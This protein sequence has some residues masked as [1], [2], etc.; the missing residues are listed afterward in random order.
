[1][2]LQAI[3]AAVREVTENWVKIPVKNTLD[4]NQEM[5]CWTH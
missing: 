3:E 5:P 2:D 1:M 4:V